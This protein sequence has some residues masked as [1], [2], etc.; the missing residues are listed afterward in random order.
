M[1]TFWIC[2]PQQHVYDDLDRNTPL[3][4]IRSAASQSVSFVESGA[5][6][7]R[8]QPSLRRWC[9]ID[10]IKASEDD[11]AETKLPGFLLRH[12]FLLS[13]TR[14][15]AYARQGN[16]HVVNGI[17]GTSKGCCLLLYG[18]GFIKLNLHCNQVYNNHYVWSNKT[19]TQSPSFI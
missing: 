13:A 15:Q 6:L 17:L 4:S 11:H 7:I 8:E 19:M 14:Q 9:I 18:G 1:S 5:D 12:F 2:T 16:V 10:T 3:S